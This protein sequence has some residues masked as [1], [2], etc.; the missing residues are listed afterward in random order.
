MDRL[1][2]MKASGWL[3]PGLAAVICLWGEAAGAERTIPAAD[4]ADKLRGMWMGQLIG[5]AAGRESEGVYSG[6]EA[7]PAEAVPWQ[8]KQVWDGDD[9]TD[10]EYVAL[11]VL[12][13]CGFDCN[14]ADITGQWLDHVTDAGIYVA[15]KQAWHL[16][17]DGHVPPETGSRRYNEHWYSI[18]AQIGTESLG[19]V[20]P[21][22]PQVAREL[23]GRFGRITNDGF[24]VHAAQF[25]AGLY[26][27]AFFDAN[28]PELIREE[29]AAVPPGSRTADVISDVLTWYDEDLSDGVP[30]W[31]ATRRLLYDKYQGGGSFGRYYNWVESTINVGATVL[32]LLYGGGDFKQTVQIAVLAGWDSDCNPAT[33]GG[34]L[35]VLH[36]VSGLPGDL[37]DPNLCGDVYQNV[38]RPGLPDPN[39][40]LP[41]YDAV[42]NIA[43]SME[44]LAEENILRNGGSVSDDNDIRVYSIPEC[45]MAPADMNTPPSIGPAGLV[46]KA[47]ATGIEVTPRASVER[48]NENLDRLNLYSIIDGVT[49]N[50]L[51]GRRPYYSYVSDVAGRPS[52]DWYELA[53]S[54]PVRFESVTFY[55]GDVVWSKLNTYIADDAAQGGFFEDLK[56]EVLRNGTYVE[57]EWVEASAA[58]DRLAMYQTITLS[59]EP[60]VGEAVRIVGTPGGSK[61]FT[62]ILELE[63][64][65][66]L[67][68]GP[69]VTA[70]TI[71]D[72]D[73][74]LIDVYT[75]VVRFDEPVTIG[76][77]DIEL[78]TGSGP[79]DLDDAELFRTSPC[80]SILLVLPSPLPAGAYELRLHCPTITDAFGLPLLDDDPNPA[81]AQWTI[82]FQII[83][84]PDAQ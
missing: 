46:G 56:V 13:T 35:G 28:V 52:I 64:R 55:E 10:I 79:F 6:A 65:G 50:S 15:N 53:F 84:N 71:G 23:A 70:A 75:I 27:R 44:A 72:G 19:A 30:D 81:D 22:M 69:G 5:N 77:D 34:L 51:N 32:A 37:T 21:G 73:E 40:A 12:L 26:A 3:A 43:M 25:Y 17:L 14:A 41:Q 74:P 33:A 78:I 57:P 61:R 42:T 2:N 58:L 49:D 36:G 63:A 45:D 80:R 9:D 59:F 62:T 7:N 67:Y 60:I 48:Y 31:R 54:K 1:G 39:A 83:A 20:S 38:F 24:A 4:L 18:D 66:E 8:I 76:L 16:M 82:R 47:L 68:A 11:H 29:L